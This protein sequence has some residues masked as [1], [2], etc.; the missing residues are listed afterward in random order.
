MRLTDEQV[1]EIRESAA[2][3]NDDVTERQLRGH[4]FNLLADREALLA[5]LSKNAADALAWGERVGRLEGENA[6]LR[7]VVAAF[8]DMA[9]VEQDDGWFAVVPREY[10]AVWALISTLEPTN[11]PDATDDNR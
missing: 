3:E 9:T 10:K 1:G 6:K 5:E 7:R 2:Y 8:R 4:V 11:V